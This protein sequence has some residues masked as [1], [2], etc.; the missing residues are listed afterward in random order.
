MH[1]ACHTAS[2]AWSGGGQVRSPYRAHP[3]LWREPKGELKAVTEVKKTTA[4]CFFFCFANSLSSGHYPP[5][6][7]QLCYY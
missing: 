2:A 7:R 3:W 6:Y 1:R 4:A 5:I